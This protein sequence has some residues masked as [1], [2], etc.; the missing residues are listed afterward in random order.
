M[1]N[2]DLKGTGSRMLDLVHFVQERDGWLTVIDR[3][4][5]LRV[6]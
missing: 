3:V 5:N 1:I 2:V 6:P 4:V